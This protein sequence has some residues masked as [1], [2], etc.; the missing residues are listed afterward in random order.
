MN[1]NLFNS[2]V[3][4][5]DDMSA[6]TSVL[7]S[8][9]IN[10]GDV[11]Y[12]DHSFYEICYVVDGTL[13]H[14]VNETQ[15]DLNAGDVIFLRPKDKH[16]YVRDNNCLSYHR[17]IIFQS[18]FFESVLNFLSPE[19]LNDYHKSYLPFKTNLSIETLEKFEKRIS[20]YLMIPSQNTKAKLVFAKTILI[21]LLYHYNKPLFT[22]E[23]DYPLLVNQIIQKL[24][25]RHVLKRGTEY[26]FTTFNYSKSHICNTFKKYM[27]VSLT[28]YIN[29]LRLNYAANLLKLTNSSL[30]NI[31]QECGFSS[32]SYFNKLFKQH[33]N[34][35]PAKFRKSPK[36]I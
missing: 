18:K 12:H 9:I 7:N 8:H 2:V 5:K 36:T 11:N 14:Y 3:H 28:E 23:N 4:L 19:L 29:E 15:M 17:D 1:K 10:R 13:P 34:C 22:A 35:T 20:E 30:Y 26:V 24:N 21:E 27:H 32:L 31:S 33:Y 25:M 16:V 6:D